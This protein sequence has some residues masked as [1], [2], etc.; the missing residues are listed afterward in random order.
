[1]Y[2]CES[3]T[4]KKAE[5][6]RTDAFEL[7]CWRR[8]LIALW[9]ARRSKPVYPKGNQSWTFIGRADAEAE[10]LILWPPDRKSWHNGKTL[11]LAKIES[12]RRRGPQ[13]MRWLDGV[14]DSMDMGLSKLWEI[15]KDREAQCAAIH[16]FT[17][18][19]TTEWLNTNTV[20]QL[21][22]K[23]PKD[24]KWYFR[25]YN[26]RRRLHTINFII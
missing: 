19:D 15:V 1:M 13:R 5:C 26:Y 17:E 10:A 9:T 20:E 8:L 2:G 21:I 7:W 4:I 24:G 18:S 25:R 12:S 6:Q 3:W 22:C 11:M 16:G 14:T 23:L